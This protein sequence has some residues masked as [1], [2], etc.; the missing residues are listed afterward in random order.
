MAGAGKKTFTAGEILTASDTNTY[1][2]EQTV[3]YFAGTAARA[4][5]IPTPSTGMT[6]YIGTTGTAS[7][8][9]LE[10]YTGSAWQTP[11]GATLL[12]NVSFSGAATVSVSNVFNATYAAYK[13]FVVSEPA[14]GNPVLNF[15]FRD[16]GGDV[17]L[18]NYNWQ[19]LLADGTTVIAARS[20]GQT[21]ASS[22]QLS[23]G[24]KSGNEVTLFDPNKAEKTVYS[25][26]CAS[27]VATG[28]IRNEAGVYNATTQFTGITFFPGSS[29]ITGNLRIYGLRNS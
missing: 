15:Q 22:G 26:T 6:T 27:G 8:P 3:M 7:I 10:T 4:S 1:L 18:T 17:S 29:T 21:Y 9:Q 16:S 19:A 20:T 23:V 14:A 28:Y 5:A 13:I 11:Y 25:N 12:A 24:T 2:M